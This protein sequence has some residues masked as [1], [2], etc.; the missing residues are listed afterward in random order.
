MSENSNRSFGGY[1]VGL[2]Y[3]PTDE[4]SFFSGLRNSEHTLVNGLFNEAHSDGGIRD[5]EFG[6]KSELDSYSSVF[7]RYIQS[8]IE[9]IDA[10]N[11]SMGFDSVST[12]GWNIGYE[13]KYNHNQFIF[14]VSKPNEVSDGRIKFL[15]P[16]ARTRSGQIVYTETQFNISDDQRFE[17]YFLLNRNLGNKRISLG[18]IEDRYNHGQIGAAKLDISF[19]F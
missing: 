5:L 14:G 9:N 19:T 16:V 18:V 6:I 3:A 13:I 11:V 4:L 15:H 10:T 1:G 17:R 12:N 7:A 2:Q 8:K